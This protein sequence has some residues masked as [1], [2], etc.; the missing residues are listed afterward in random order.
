M[1][2]PGF[3]VLLLCLTSAALAEESDLNQ[4]AQQLVA[5]FAGELRPALATAMQSG[6]P[7]H[8]I[9]VCATKAPD[10]ARRLSMESGWHVR[11]VSLRPRNMETAVADAW[12]AGV[13]AD[14][15]RRQKAGEAVQS[16]THSEVVG[17]E[18]R[19][20]KAQATE[21]LCLTCH[22]KALAPAVS[23][24]IKAKYPRDKATGYDLGEI[25]GAFYLTKH[26]PIR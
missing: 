5:R 23:E 12:A 3:T 19:F 9:D 20:L 26:Q 2:K 16:L 4:Q 11:R 13:L 10:I 22:G 17:D 21:P 25:R 14:F 1:I 24:A 18:F 7:V 6:G 15:D 8:A